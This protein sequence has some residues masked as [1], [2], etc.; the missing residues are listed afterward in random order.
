MHSSTN[1]SPFEACYGY[2]PRSPLDFIF[3]KYVAI[4]GHINIDKARNFI[5]KIWLIHHTMQ[6]QLEKIKA[7]TMQGMKNT[8]L[9]KIF[10][11]AVKFC[12]ILAKRDFKGKV[13]ILNQSVMVLLKFWKRLVTMHLSDLGGR[14]WPPTYPIWTPTTISF[15]LF[16]FLNCSTVYYF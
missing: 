3:E 7:A 13:K 12:Y 1:T 4:D 16:S 8:R 11:L 2:L 9:I 10:K 6:E 5:E 14:W 15:S